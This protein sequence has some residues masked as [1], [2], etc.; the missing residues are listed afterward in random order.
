MQNITASIIIPVYNKECYIEECLR[1]VLTQKCS[2]P[3]EIIC[4]NDGSTDRSTDI[5]SK[6]QKKYNNLILLNQDNKGVSSARNK[7]I[8]AASGKFLFFVDADDSISSNTL[9]DVI[10]FFEKNQDNIDIVTYPIFYKKGKYI[11]QGKRG[12]EIKESCII[13]IATWPDFSQ[14]TMNVCVKN[15]KKILFREDLCICEDQFYNTEHILQK[16]MIGWCNTGKYIYRKGIGGASDLSHPN[17]TFDMFINFIWSLHNIA[18]NSVALAYI[19]HLFL[20]NMAWRI[21]SNMVFPF[22]YVGEQYEIAVQKIVNILDK[23][24]NKAIL[25]NSWLL[26]HHKIYLLSIKRKDRLIPRLTDDHWGLCQ[27]DKYIIQ[28]KKINFTIIQALIHGHKLYIKGYLSSPI[29]N[30]ISDSPELLLIK[31]N[32][33]KKIDVFI[34]PESCFHSD[35]QTNVFWGVETN[36]DIAEF[37]NVSFAVY[38]CGKH[39]EIEYFFANSCVIND[40]TGNTLIYDRPLSI[41]FKDNIFCV[42]NYKNVRHKHWQFL[43]IFFTDQKRR[44]FLRLC[45]II[46]KRWKIYLYCGR[47]EISDSAYQAY[48]NDRSLKDGNHRFFVA[49]PKTLAKSHKI[50]KEKIYFISF[51]SLTHKALFLA[52]QKLYTS[53][54]KDYVPFGNVFAYYADLV[55]MDIVYCSPMKPRHR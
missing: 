16:N 36:V 9:Q 19:D 35:I 4:I 29:F 47:D 27:N 13:D 5:I 28:S 1:S 8:K 48:M 12:K 55:D 34:S 32:K 51:K 44:L 14:T 31:D 42:Y 3:T 37:E 40:I 2:Y 43:K 50:T 54:Q 15:E 41:E 49:I 46:L 7:G 39:Y 26:Y 38:V 22:P 17:Y 25:Q 33:N 30:F 23:I 52:T 45:A 6:L 24:D 20:Y 53:L 11:H 21:K 10:V 18:Q